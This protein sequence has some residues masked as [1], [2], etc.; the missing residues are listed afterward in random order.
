MLQLNH[1]SQNRKQSES[2]SEA[3]SFAERVI[4]WTI[5]LTPLWW[6]MGIQ[7]I[8]YPIVSVF[9]LVAGL[10]LDKL[11]KQ[12]LPICNWAWLGMIFAALW[13]NILGLESIGF[14]A[15]KTAATLFTLFKGYLMIFACMT[16]PFWHRIQVKTIVR[17]V[18]WM[19]AG[20]LVTLAIQLIILFVMGPQESILPPLARLIPGEKESMMVKFATIRAFFGVPLPRAVLYTADPPILGVCGLLCFFMCLGESN[21]RLRKFAIAGSIISLIISQSRLAWIC[22]PLV[23]LIIYCFRSGLARQ[24]Y[25]WIVSLISL[26]AA[27]L[28][29]SVQDLIA[30]P[31]ATFNSGRPESSKDREYVINATIDAWKDSPWLGWGVMDKTVSWGNGAFVLPLGTFSSYAKVLYIHG[32]L[33]FIFF[34]AA[35]V[36]TL[37]SFWEPA[38]KGN[39]ICQRAFGCLVALY[40]LLHATNLTWMAIYFWFFFVWLGAI[41]SEQQQQ[42][43]NV[44]QWEELIGN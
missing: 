7:T 38:I 3:K 15:L 43:L 26:F 44:S 21:Q 1:F 32:I 36:S 4:Y 30:L 35:L 40:L 29:L 18:S 20:L 31:L 2:K 33:G 9:L 37:C 34:I 42:D 22:F 13:T 24:G 41:L 25:L 19:T 8:V 14:P 10:K 39:P 23:W 27:V 5:V 12:S 16:L 11:M 28:S 17:A 6:L